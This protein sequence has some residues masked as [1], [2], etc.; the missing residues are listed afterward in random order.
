MKY[1]FG[2]GGFYLNRPVYIQLYQVVWSVRYWKTIIQEI[3]NQEL[4]SLWVECTKK[5][6]SIN[7][8][9]G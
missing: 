3:I 6:F 7:D 9:S 4:A 1:E 5:K 2:K 8:E